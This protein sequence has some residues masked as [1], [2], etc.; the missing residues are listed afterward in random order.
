MATQTPSLSNKERCK[1]VN[2]KKINDSAPLE[3]KVTC[4]SQ[5]N[6]FNTEIE[7]Q[8]KQNQQQISEE[9]FTDTVNFFHKI[10]EPKMERKWDS[11]NSG[12][13]ESNEENQETDESSENEDETKDNLE[14][15]YCLNGSQ[16]A[17]QP[18]RKSISLCRHKL[19]GRTRCKTRKWRQ[20]SRQYKR[21]WLPEPEAAQQT[22]LNLLDTEADPEWVQL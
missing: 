16:P 4:R 1:S 18:R 15:L 14:D 12:Y 17:N 21:T 19:Q 7:Q 3:Q 6:T 11:I 9:E 2:W 8:W 22:D 13:S 5:M 20:Q 10:R